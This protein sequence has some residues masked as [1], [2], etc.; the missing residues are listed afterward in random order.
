MVYVAEIFVDIRDAKTNASLT[1][2]VVNGNGT[3]Y[4]AS[5]SVGYSLLSDKSP[6]DIIARKTGYLTSKEKV[7]PIAN[8]RTKTVTLFAS[9]IVV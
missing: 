5:G 6:M 7:Y 8:E 4:N 2:F 9:A 1:G 3:K